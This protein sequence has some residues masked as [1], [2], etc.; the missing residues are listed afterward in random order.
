M[1]VKQQREAVQKRIFENPTVVMF[2]VFPEKDNGLGITVRDLTGTPVNK[3]ER[4]RI[5]H[6]DPN[7]QGN[8]DIPTGRGTSFG[9]YLIMMHDSL[10]EE[11]MEITG[12]GKKWKVG[13]VDELRYD[14]KVYERLAPLTEVM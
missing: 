12:D 10:I 6:R 2:Q 1:S 9:M 7:L 8:E 4:V 5:S 13:P 11:G 14:S 3:K